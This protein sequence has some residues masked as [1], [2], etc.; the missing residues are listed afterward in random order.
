MLLHSQMSGGV[1]DS[2]H[3]RLLQQVLLVVLLIQYH[4]SICAQSYLL[5]EAVVDP[6]LSPWRKLY[7]HGDR[8][9]FLHMTGLTRS[10]FRSL[11]DYLFDL[12]AI[13]RH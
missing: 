10:A 8:N 9:S 3:M 7:D 4:N 2:R 12:D 13:V 6:N 5:R 11:L 1:I